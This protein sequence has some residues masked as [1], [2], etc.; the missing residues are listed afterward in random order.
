MS[1]IGVDTNVL[2]RLFITDDPAQMELSKAFFAEETG[3][4]KIFINRLVMLEF[5]WVLRSRY[6]LPS[7]RI[8]DVIE[9]I[10][11]Q[12]NIEVDGEALVRA[13]VDLAREGAGFADALIAASNRQGNCQHTVTFDVHAARTIPFM[14]LLT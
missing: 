3:G 12:P 11:E 14:H 13:A 5:F 7:T 10:L 2:V 4:R 8:L 6:R 9:Q 1:L